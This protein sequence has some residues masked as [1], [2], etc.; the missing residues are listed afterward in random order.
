[1][2]ASTKRP[3]KF[4]S[5]VI[6]LLLIN[7]GFF[8]IWFAL[9]GRSYF[10][11]AIFHIAG[12]KLGLEIS[13]GDM[14][15]SERQVY[16]QNISVADK[17]GTFD[18]KVEHL[19]VR[20]N[21]YKLLSSKLKLDGVISSVEIEKPTVQLKLRQDRKEEKKPPKRKKDEIP[22]FSPYFERLSITGGSFYADMA[23]QL[24]IQEDDYL[25]IEESL[26]NINIK[27]INSEVSHLNLKANTAM[28]GV[29]SLQGILDK[30]Q[31]RGSSLSL[32][33]YQPLYVEHKD[34]K[35]IRTKLDLTA[36]YKGDLDLEQ[37]QYELELTMDN[38]SLYAI[39]RLPVNI[40]ALSFK[41]DESTAHLLLP[42]VTVANSSL[43]ADLSVQNYWNKISFNGTTAKLNTNLSDI[44]PQ[45]S[46]IVKAELAGSGGIDEPDLKLWAYSEQVSYQD[47]AFDDIFLEAHYDGEN[48]VCE[49]LK[50]LWQNQI[51]EADCQLNTLSMEFVANLSTEPKP[52]LEG[53]VAASGTLKADG[54]LIFPYP[55]VNAELTNINISYE[56]LTLSDINGK[57]VLSPLDE[58]LYLHSYLDSA[59][60]FYLDLAGELFSRHI[61]LDIGFEAIDVASIYSMPTLKEVSPLIS[62]ELKLILLGSK[63]WFDGDLD[64]SADLIYPFSGKLNILGSMDLEDIKVNLALSSSDSR[65]NFQ[66][67]PFSLVGSYYK[68][69]IK[70]NSAHVSDMI[71][72]SGNLNLY[73]IQDMDFEL[74]LRNI[75]STKI[76][77][78]Y[79]DLASYFPDFEDID[80]F[81]C[82]NRRM[83]N[84]M[85]ANL[86]LWQVDLISLIPLDFSLNLEGKPNQI[87]L[88]GEIKDRNELLMSLNGT[89]SMFPTQNIALSA[90]MHNLSIEELL[91]QELAK[92]SLYGSIGFELLNIGQ[93]EKQR[94]SISAD[95]LAQNLSIDENTIDE[96]RIKGVQEPNAL[97]I[98][99]L[100]VFADNLF[101]ARAKGALD[102]NVLQNMY[103][104]G[105]STL[106]FFIDAKLF[107][108]VKELTDYVRES[109]GST[110]ITATIGTNEEQFVFLSGGIDVLDGHLLLKDQ[111]EPMRNIEIRAFFDNN[112]LIVERGQFNMGNGKL[113][114]NNLFDPDPEE[115]FLLGFLDLGYFRIMI[116]EPGIQATIPYIAP[117]KTLTSVS[118]KGQNSRYATMRGPFD[119]MQ[120]E[121]HLTA[122]N[123]DILFPPGADNLLNLIMS[124]R[125]TGKKPDTE[126]L[127]LPFHLD[128]LVNIG[129]NVRY[130]TYPT[131][132]YI[133][134][135]GFLH[136]IY[137]GNQ[138]IVKEAN[139]SSDRGNIDFF[140][141]VFEVDNISI[142]MIDQQDV[143]S[144]YGEFYKRSPDGSIV[145]LIIK[146]DNDYEKNFFDR[147]QLSLQSD[148]PND[149]NISQILSR[150][151]YNQSMDDIPEDQRQN[152]LQDEALGLIGEN[153]NSAVL[154]P[155]MFPVENWIRRTLKLDTF[156]IKAGF[157]Q[158]LFNDYYSNR[159]EFNKMTQMEDIASDVSRFS[160]SILLNNLSLSM[161][162][163]IAY[164]TFADYKLTLQ[165]ATDLQ[166]K[167]KILVSQDA[168][169]RLILPRQLR[170]GYTLQYSP[171]DLGLTHEVMI[172]KTWRF[173]GL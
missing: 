26:N 48:V 110:R 64:S 173:W 36:N 118:L 62:G 128:V 5:L 166:K 139:I 146:S 45:L 10:Q 68:G 78:Y 21:L 91:V 35:R 170:L 158:N 144:V 73:Q 72:L 171:K 9:G 147:L 32:K 92:G 116:E 148:N 111:I 107:G 37:G 38:T 85:K 122:S 126:P 18:V 164:R 133:E 1:M 3:R 169:V 83:D 63:L 14:H 77:S 121:A 153:I 112:R 140:G 80:L 41:G 142:T 40:P 130:V 151:R 57:I 97:V 125:K 168:S 66:D 102:Y 127:S 81:A 143:L 106:E 8:T 17:K 105:D 67:L 138:F 101:E 152:I 60:G 7:V 22:D 99:S 131:N 54:L 12:K 47:L 162:K 70:L 159:D 109:S 155:F 2:V 157:I 20:Y 76:I 79:P 124:V 132:L 74:S 75:S 49:S 113:L 161:S 58:A 88:N 43:I 29:L 39:N 82:Y 123:L 24:K 86:N 6:V 117:P 87:A 160:S 55:L 50:A 119:D 93:K 28:G 25:K 33:S 104:E 16:L 149:R 13:I 89:G 150:M 100:Y 120:I 137:D 98:D 90:F 11:N 172:Q 23:F 53:I 59:D 30:G 69:K 114:I 145:S 136:L 95:M 141:T 71:S 84:Y 31:I 108:W 103:F 51:L 44:M 163:Y 94:M 65:Y 154:N 96:I 165:E 27:V 115:H 56:E 129:D 15:L 4:F 52:Q 61:A 135:G 42:N 46:G 19:R 34:L 167:T 156:S 134:P